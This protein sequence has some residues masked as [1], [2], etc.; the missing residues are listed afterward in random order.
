MLAQARER[1][2]RKV[3]LS[4]VTLPDLAVE[5]VFDAAVCTFDGL[6][7]LA[8]AQLRQTMALVAPRLRPA[9]WSSSTSTPTR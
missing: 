2:G 3:A 5:G 1:L 9:G 6:N 8:P 4:R 7:Y